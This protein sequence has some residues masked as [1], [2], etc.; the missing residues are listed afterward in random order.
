MTRLGADVFRFRSQFER[1]VPLELRLGFTPGL[2]FAYIGA[3]TTGDGRDPTGR[4]EQR[5]MSHAVDLSGR[6]D[7]PAPLRWAIPRPLRLSFSYDYEEQLQS[8]IV[9]ELAEP[10]PFVDHINRRVNLTVSSLFAQ[11]DVGL[12]ASYVDRRSFIGTQAGSSQFQLG[13]FGQFNVQAG[14]LR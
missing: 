13:I 3:R 4:T 5:S 12:Q 11:M 8:R 7:A 10:T 14:D 9:N 1:T 6:F 2:A